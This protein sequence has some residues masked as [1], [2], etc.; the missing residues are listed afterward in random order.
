MNPEERRMY[1]LKN[2]HKYTKGGKYY[3]YKPKESEGKFKI[4]HKK[5]IIYF[6]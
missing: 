6:S 3:N 2:K 1:Y 5:V 4:V